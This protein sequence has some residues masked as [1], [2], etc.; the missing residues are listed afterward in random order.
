MQILTHCWEA[1]EVV[2]ELTE[3]LQFNNFIR[4][5]LKFKMLSLSFKLS[6]YDFVAC[7]FLWWVRACE[8]GQLRRH[9]R[10]SAISV[11]WWTLTHSQGFISFCLR[12][13]V[14]SGKLW[15]HSNHF[16]LALFPISLT[17]SPWSGSPP[18]RTARGS[19]TTTTTTSTPPLL[20]ITTQMLSAM[21]REQKDEQD[22]TKLQP[23]FAIF[24][25]LFKRHSSQLKQS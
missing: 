4:W 3:V 12:P 24:N 5:I 21:A 9:R 10:Q 15:H 11:R 25:T 7:R 17:S 1:E 19:T 23:N 13:I 22:W 2:T 16:L 20:P 6:M 18:W 8:P 14:E